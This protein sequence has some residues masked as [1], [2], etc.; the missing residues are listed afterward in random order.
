MVA[1]LCRLRVRV[2]IQRLLLRDLAVAD[3]A[4]VVHTA[5]VPAEVRTEA[6]ADRMEVLAGTD[7]Q[8]ITDKKFLS[9][10]KHDRRGDLKGLPRRLC[11]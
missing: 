5:A 3:R 2:E 11:F 1:H 6:R 10:P 9:Q 4:A 8:D 7:R